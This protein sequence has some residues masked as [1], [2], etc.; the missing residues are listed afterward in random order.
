MLS[1]TDDDLF[2]LG[3]TYSFGQQY[4]QHPPFQFQQYQMPLQSSPGFPQ[5]TGTS[6]STN[7][8]GSMASLTSAMATPAAYVNSA[9]YGSMVSNDVSANIMSHDFMYGDQYNS[10]SDYFLP[11]M[12]FSTDFETRF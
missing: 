1:H 9:S 7:R 5:S 10:S 8:T 11:N 6:I 12:N 3:S 4:G 2:G